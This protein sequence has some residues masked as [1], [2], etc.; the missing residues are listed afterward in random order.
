MLQWTW[1]CI[2]LFKLIFSF[3]SNKYPRVDHMVVLFLIFLKNLHTVF[4]SGYTNLYSHQQCMRVPF[5]PHPHQHLLLFAFLMIAILSD[6]RWVSVV[7]NCIS[8]L[9]S[10]FWHLF[11]CLSAICMSSFWEN[12]YSGTLPILDCFFDVELYEFFVY[13]ES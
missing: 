12:V 4:Q 10:D 7:F 11:L 5:S 1:G 8:L 6:V 3:S 2:C 13:F 9:I